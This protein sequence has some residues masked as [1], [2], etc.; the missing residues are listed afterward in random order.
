[1]W[2]TICSIWT[3]YTYSRQFVVRGRITDIR[4]GSFT[5][6]GSHGV[7]WGSHHKPGFHYYTTLSPYLL[8]PGNNTIGSF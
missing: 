4:P 6:V 2:V 3:W 8:L 7:K 5:K 1:M